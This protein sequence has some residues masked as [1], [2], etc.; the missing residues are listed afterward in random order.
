M[1]RIYS[2]PYH[3]CQTIPNKNLH[4]AARN[5]I[6]ATNILVNATHAT[7]D[8]TERA[9]I[10]MSIP[11][12]IELLATIHTVAHEINPHR[13]ALP[14]ANTITRQPETT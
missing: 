3:G 1:S 11:L 7:T 12:F 13:L 14:E 9:I 8:G 2:D 10:N 6:A 4:L 5:L